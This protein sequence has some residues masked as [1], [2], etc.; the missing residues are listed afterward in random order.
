LP[1]N[2]ISNFSWITY[3]WENFSWRLSSL[4]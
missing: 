3:Q 4:N 1:V 2:L